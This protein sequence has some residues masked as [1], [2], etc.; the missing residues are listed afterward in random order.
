[1]VLPTG[2]SGEA[3]V[4]EQVGSSDLG[5]QGLEVVLPHA[6]QH[7]VA[8][9]GL[10]GLHDA[11]TAPPLTL[12]PHG[13]EV[14]DDVGHGDGRV[15][16]GDVDLLAGAGPVPV[17][18]RRQDPHGTEQRRADVAQGTDRVGG[19]RTARGALV[20]VDAGH[21]LDDR[22]IGTHVPV[23]RTLIL[24][25]ARDGE[26]DDRWMH[27]PD[28]LVPDAQAIGGTGPEVLAHDVEAGCHPQ[29]QLDTLRVLQVDADAALVQVVAKE[30]GAHLATIGVRHEGL[31]ST[32]A[33]AGHRML[34]LDHL[35]TQAGQ[36][37]GGEREGRH[38]LDGQDPYAVKRPGNLLVGGCHRDQSA[39]RGRLAG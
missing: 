27:R 30:G 23:R 26:V 29:E 10:E 18:Q 21:S 35:G 39:L 15:Q 37:L 32:T 2:A 24:A 7:E 33:V 16:H 11:H 25:E 6:L 5:H 3:P 4:I 17:S 12:D 34:D 13:V 22:R 9:G 31:G 14:G 36:Q 8:V 20:L 28:G 19:R 1:M 38:L